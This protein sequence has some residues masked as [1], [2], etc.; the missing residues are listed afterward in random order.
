MG[1]MIA[2]KAIGHPVFGI[3]FTT[4]VEGCQR[5]GNAAK[6]RVFMSMICH[7]FR[8]DRQRGKA[9]RLN[10]LTAIKLAGYKLSDVQHFV[11]KVRYCLQNI[12]KTEKKKSPRKQLHV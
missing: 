8:T 12:D 7:R 1:S 9:I 2:E 10:N 11:D 6:G 4:Y 3:K 5:R